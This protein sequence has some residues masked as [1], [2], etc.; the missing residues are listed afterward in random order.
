[1]N[2]TKRCPHCAE[3]IKTEA[4]RCK[5]CK[6]NLEGMVANPATPSTG[7]TI[8][9]TKCTCQACGNVWFYG[10]QDVTQNSANAMGNL[11][12]S[13]MCC[14]GCWPALLIP[15]KKVVNVNKCPKCNSAAVTKEQV[16]Y[17][18]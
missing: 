5:H 15:D 9:E 1:M 3:E 10:K 7:K 12:K 13:M 4:L 6:T 14:G 17:A 16:T 2:D 8:Q 11:G 18:V